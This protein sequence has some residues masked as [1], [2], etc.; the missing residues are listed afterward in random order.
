M[1]DITEYERHLREDLDEEELDELVHDLKG[2]EA[3]RINN[4]GKESQINYIM[5]R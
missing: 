4:G 1:S 2:E 5:G 3:A